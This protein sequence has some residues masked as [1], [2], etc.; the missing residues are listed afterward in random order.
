MPEFEDI[1]SKSFPH[2]KAS[3]VDSTEVRPES[4]N[5][6]IEAGLRRG[7]LGRHI[8]LIS[9]ASVIGASCFYGFG[10]ALYLSGPLGAL[11]GFGIVGKSPSINQVSTHVADDDGGWIVWA[12]MQSVGEVT[13]MF[14]IAGGFIEVSPLSFL[15]LTPVL[16]L[17]ARKSFRRPSLQLRHGLDVLLHVV[18]VP[19]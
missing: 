16:T 8:S 6:I 5:I 15:L 18:G 3:P 19:G 1:E 13:T 9:L 14:P 12:L 7:L 17:S 11:L 2:E 4:E 10:Y